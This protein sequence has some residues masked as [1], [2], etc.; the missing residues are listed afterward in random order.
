MARLTKKTALTI[1]KEEL[2][3]MVANGTF[4]K[5]DKIAFNQAWGIFTD[6]LCKDNLISQ[7]QYDTWC[8]PF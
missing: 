4:G 6:S 8:N 5:K 1:F 2:A 3:I 7:Q